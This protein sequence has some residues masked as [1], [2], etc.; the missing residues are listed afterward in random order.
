MIGRMERP[1]TRSLLATFIE[2]AAKG[3]VTPIEW[4]RF[5]INHYHDEAM[6]QAR[7]ECVRVLGIVGKGDHRNVPKPDLDR[8][9]S[10]ARDLRAGELGTERMHSE[11]QHDR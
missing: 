4:S 8:L 2:Y 1:I 3:C 9:L 7:R 5:A 11:K 6:E 10:L